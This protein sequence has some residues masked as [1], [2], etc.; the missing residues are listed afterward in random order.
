MLVISEYNFGRYSEKK[1]NK[2]QTIEVTLIIAVKIRILLKTH[3][4]HTNTHSYILS[5]SIVCLSSLKVIVLIV[6]MKRMQQLAY[7][8]NE[9]RKH[10]INEQC[11]ALFTELE[12]FIAI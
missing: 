12:Y 4:P 1:S 8:V 10:N 6:L 9:N 2:T 7:S 3:V 5:I 11:W